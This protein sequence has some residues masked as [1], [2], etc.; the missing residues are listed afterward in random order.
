MDR[1]NLGRKR[2]APPPRVNDFE[3]ARRSQRNDMF[4]TDED[5]GDSIFGADDVLVI[6]NNE[7]GNQ[8]SPPQSQPLRGGYNDN[9]HNTQN[10]ARVPNHQNLN[11]RINRQTNNSMRPPVSVR[12]APP[13]SIRHVPETIQIKDEDTDNEIAM[14]SEYLRTVPPS[15]L[16]KI[17]VGRKNRSIVVKRLD[18]SKSPTLQSYIVD[19]PV[20]GSFIMRPQ[21]MNTHYDDFAAV[22]HFLHAG[23]YKPLL[24]ENSI[25][26]QG[27]KILSGLKGD[28]DYAKELVKSGKLYGLA[29]VFGIQGM[30]DLVFRKVSEVDAGK[31]SISSLVRVAEVV[32][33]D[34]KGE[35]ETVT[36]PNN[37]N[38]GD[39]NNQDEGTGGSPE[40]GET[41]SQDPLEE[42]IIGKLAYNYQEIMRTQQEKFFEVVKTTGKKLL[43]AKVLEEVATKYRA[44]GGKLPEPVIE[45]D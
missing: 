18:L 32:F 40:G 1:S 19:D 31:F 5:D 10:S 23:E 42:W 30:A 25:D 16:V 11:G 14:D 7:M 21:L 35:S 34:R 39:G 44:S 8:R 22:A 20:Q 9:R 41:S 27:P 24:V 12:S 2:P 6:E 28:E 3:V 15:Q 13:A 45:L 33:K 4:F 36:R 43:F 37:S 38:N 29:K 26:R 17:F